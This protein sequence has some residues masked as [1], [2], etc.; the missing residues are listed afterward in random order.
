[1]QNLPKIVTQ[2]LNLVAPHGG[3]PDPNLLTA[4]AERAL[5]P[6]ERA[7]LT[8]HLSFCA[9][10]RAIVFLAQPD[11][12]TTS[13]A[14]LQP[15][16]HGWFTMPI[17]RWGLVAS[18][19]VVF[20]GAGILLHQR[21]TRLELARS[22]AP[23]TVVSLEKEKEQGLRQKK[24]QGLEEKKEQGSETVQDLQKAQGTP[25]AAPPPN[26]LSAASSNRVPAAALP[27][28]KKSAAQDQIEASATES[29]Q[30][31][32][33]LAAGGNRANAPS[34]AAPAGTYSLAVSARAPQELARAQKSQTAS[35]DG[36]RVL[37]YSQGAPVAANTPP[38]PAAIPQSSEVLEVQ[39]ATQATTPGVAAGSIPN[40]FTPRDAPSNGRAP[41]EL[42]QS[43]A[44]PNDRKQSDRNTVAVST[45]PMVG[46]T[47]TGSAQAAV[48]APLRLP[49]WSIGPAGILERSFDDGKTWQSVD[50]SLK[51]QPSADNLLQAQVTAKA[52]DQS[53]LQHDKDRIS[54]IIFYSVAVR[55]P[56]VWA[57]GTAGA[58]YHSSDAGNFWVRLLPSANGVA[59]SGDVVRIEFT[60]QQGCQV[61]TSTAE[62]WNT[63]DDGQSWQKQ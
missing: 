16:R 43:N 20:A 63:A 36:A 38:M 17:L 53:S 37:P 33:S 45:G 23:A 41:I 48:V 26:Q 7:L 44:E 29:K 42:K 35:G 39:S 13:A 1:M 49:S 24:E 30:S 2:Q 5:P 25:A 46:A 34:R 31:R 62:I 14:V 4:F 19:I 9:D 22:A 18:C 27:F 52:K 61:T 28:A 51:P 12:E 57:G 21:T 54:H 50:V 56:E 8:D 47:G 40:Q 59:L 55:G 3:H 32:N 58:L 60:G 15:A 11:F 10:C 6:S